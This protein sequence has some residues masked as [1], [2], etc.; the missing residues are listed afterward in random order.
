V[1]YG[2]AVSRPTGGAWAWLFRAI[3]GNSVGLRRTPKL[4]D[5]GDGA[6]S[7]IRSIRRPFDGTSGAFYHRNGRRSRTLAA[8]PN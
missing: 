8:N 5:S 7:V 6:P 1:G 3:T 4:G 2:P